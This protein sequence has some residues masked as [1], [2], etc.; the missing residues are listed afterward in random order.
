MPIRRR[1]FLKLAMAAPAIAS[2]PRFADA[3][4]GYPIYDL[5]PFG[6]ARILHMTDTH[7][8]LLPVYFREPSINIGV[9]SMRARPPHLVGDGFLTQFNVAPGSAEAQIGRAH[10]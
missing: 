1:D 9:G 6:N 4:K 2:F 10:V 8:Q 7:A 5:K 3:A